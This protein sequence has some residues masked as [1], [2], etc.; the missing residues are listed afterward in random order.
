MAPYHPTLE[1]FLQS[2]NLA[3]NSFHGGIPSKVVYLTRLGNLNLSHNPILGGEIPINL[4]HYSNLQYLDLQYNNLVQGIPLEL[5]SLSKLQILILDNNRLSGRFP[6]SL[7]NLSSLQNLSFAYNNLEGE[8][9]NTVAQMKSL[10]S[11]IVSENH[12]SIVFPPSLYNLSLL[13]RISLPDNNFIGN[14]NPNLG[15]ALQNLQILHIAR[16]QFIGTITVSLSNV[17]DIQSLDI[18]GINLQEPYL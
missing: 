15:I 6:P 2:L 5:C 13:T 8:I 7:G 1:I 3:S 17:L 11:F 18:L 12:L 10:T 9:P 16:N 14:L 4:S